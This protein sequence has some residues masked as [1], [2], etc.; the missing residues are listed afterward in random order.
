MKYIEEYLSQFYPSTAPN[1]FAKLKEKVL[2]LEE[3][4][5]IHRIYEDD[6]VFMMKDG[7]LR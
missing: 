3:Q 6:V 7:V 4:P 5:F 1:F 2:Q